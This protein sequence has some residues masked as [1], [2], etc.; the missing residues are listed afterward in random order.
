[1]HKGEDFIEVLPAMALCFVLAL[2]GFFIG[3]TV[4][5]KR[6]KVNDVKAGVAHW[7][8]DEWGSAKFE[9]NK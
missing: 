5:E 9:Y 4:G 6:Q 1:M 8:C 7:G 2:S 3:V